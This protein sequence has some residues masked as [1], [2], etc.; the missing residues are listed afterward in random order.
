MSQLHTISSWSDVVNGV[1]PTA[2]ATT[3]IFLCLG[4]SVLGAGWGIFLTGSSIV[5]AAVKAPRIRSRNLVSIVFCEVVAIYGVIFTIIL[6]TK[7]GAF[8]EYDNI[9]HLDPTT[10]T[11]N[12]KLNQVAGWGILWS[13][14]TVGFSNLVCGMS[15]GVAGSGCA[16]GDAQRPELYLRMLVVEIFASALGLFGVIVAILQSGFSQ[17][18][19]VL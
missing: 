8:P 12:A 3:G 16:L 10:G 2:W 9:S 4:I 5:G 1:N 18:A 11:L 19:S 17:F 7:I 6:N 13:G 15:V 14:A